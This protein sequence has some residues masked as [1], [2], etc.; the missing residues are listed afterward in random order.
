[1]NLQALFASPIVEQ[2]YLDPGYSGHA[3]DVWRVTTT[4]EAVIVRAVREGKVS[5]PFWQGCQSL[6]GINPRH[7]FDLARLNAVLARLSP[8]PVPQ[9]L[10]KGV[11][12]GR[13]WVV[14]EH[15]PG[16]MLTDFSSLPEDAME[17]LGQT[18]ARI[19]SSRMGY[20]GQPT[21]RVQHDLATFP[22][23]LVETMRMLVEQFY[24]GDAQIT[25]WLE[26]LCK[27]ALMLP[28]PEAG[29]LIMVDMDPTQF[30]TDGRRLTALVDTEAY[31]VGPRELDFI[32]LEYL[33][34]QQEV[35]ALARGYNAI[36]PL[37]ELSAVRP[38][39]RYLYRLLEAQGRMELA[40]WMAYPARF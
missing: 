39:Y 11:L 38:V 24:L 35:E 17:S 12:A 34:T 4:Q 15:M 30:L 14:V 16:V 19:H 37:P 10:R 27:T 7:I 1:M 32:A 36:Q 26:P 20:Y 8:I 5:G 13:A 25:E 18:L 21:G 29:A 28:A 23:R 33:L 2:V 6:F 3:S 40:A 9:V 31:A 22:T